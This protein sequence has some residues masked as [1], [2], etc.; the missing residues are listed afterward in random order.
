LD[1][2]EVE[3][4]QIAEQVDLLHL[5]RDQFESSMQQ[6]GLIVGLFDLACHDPLQGL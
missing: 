4:R 1:A 3:Q 2:V 6:D 5:Q